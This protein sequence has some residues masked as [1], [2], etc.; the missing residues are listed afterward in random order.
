MTY[1][2]DNWVVVSMNTKTPHYKLLAGNSGGYLD[3]DSWRMNSGIV[4]VKKE[5]E[6]WLFTGS[7]GSVYKCHEQAYCLRLNNAYV[8]RALKDKHGDKVEIMPEDTDWS[9]MDWRLK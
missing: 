8:W 7:S 5:D 3:G 4:G 6:Y 1:T 2:P 9:T